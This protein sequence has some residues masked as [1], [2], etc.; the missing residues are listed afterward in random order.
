[1]QT[2]AGNGPVP[3]LGRARSSWRCWPSGLAYSMATSKRTVSGTDS[4]EIGFCA[5]AEVTRDAQA[6]RIASDR[7]KIQGMRLHIRGSLSLSVSTNG[8]LLADMARDCCGG[9]YQRNE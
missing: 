4:L 2:T 9:Y 8:Q 7:T 6:R 1:M 3:V 5:R